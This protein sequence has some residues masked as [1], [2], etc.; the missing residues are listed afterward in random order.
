LSPK[1]EKHS[2]ESRLIVIAAPS[3]AGKTTLCEMLLREFPN[4][5]LSISATTRPRR[6]TEIEGVHYFFHSADQ[7]QSKVDS[8]EFA[9][10]ANVHH[11]MYGTPKAAIEQWLEQGSHVLFD[12]DVQ[13]AMSLLSQ[14]REKVVLIF[15]HPPSLEVL[16]RRLIDRRGD[17]LPS[18]ENRLKAASGEIEWS[19]SFDYHITN[20]ELEKAYRELKEIVQKECP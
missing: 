12:I 3:G 9:E 13:G 14:Y 10:W 8:G 11:H 1:R 7:F 2:S 19:K 18:I 17:T 16:Q 6:A 4:I 5:K 15:I 20:D